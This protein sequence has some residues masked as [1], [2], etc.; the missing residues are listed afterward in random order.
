MLEQPRKT[1]NEGGNCILGSTAGPRLAAGFPVAEAGGIEALTLL[2]EGGSCGSCLDC[3]GERCDEI[4]PSMIS[5]SSDDSLLE[6]TG[7]VQI[8]KVS[9]L[10]SPLALGDGS[11]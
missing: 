5:P 3:R 11:S 4:R 8:C 1:S 2:D 10:D 6:M 7:R 9:S